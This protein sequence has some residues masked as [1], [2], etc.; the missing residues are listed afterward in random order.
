MTVTVKKK[1][2]LLSID[3]NSGEKPEKKKKNVK[4][5][6]SRKKTPKTL[7]IVESP[8]KARTIN[9]YLKSGYIVEAC[10]GH[11]I[12]LPKSRLAVDVEHDFAPE[13]ITV[14]GRAQILNRLKRLAANSRKV[15]IA[16][17]PDREGEAIAWHL[18]NVL[19]K[20]LADK[21]PPIR[22][23]EFNEISENAIREVVLDEKKHR[24]INMNLVNAQQA[25]RILDRL[26]GYNISP[27]L[28]QKIKRGLSAGRVQSVAL[29]QICMREKSILKFKPEEYWK[30]Q[31]ELKF[32][33]STITADLIKWDGKKINIKDKS[34]SN[35]IC[36]ILREA[37]YLVTGIREREKKRH[38]TPPY[39]TSKLQQD[40]S[41]R[42]SFASQKTMIVAQQLYEGVQIDEKNAS[43][44][45]TYM[46]TDSTR[47]SDRA[48]LSLHQYIAKEYGS[49][50]LKQRTYRTSKKAQDAHEA[51]RPV[52]VQKH[53]QKIKSYLTKDQF[54]LYEMIW[55]KFVSSQMADEVAK[56]LTIEIRADKGLLAARESHVLFPGFTKVFGSLKKKESQKSS[57][58]PQLKKDAPLS[59]HKLLPSQHFTQ[60]PPRFND[61]SLVKILEESGVGRPSTYA[62]TIQ[63]LQKRY[64]ITRINKAF[65]P[66]EVGNIVNQI[67]E[68]HFTDLVDIGFTAKMEDSLDQIAQGQLDEENDNKKKN[69]GTKENW[70]N[71]LHNFYPPFAE[72]IS[73]A[74]VEIE[75]LKG[76]LDK[77]TDY[78]C[79]K[80]DTNMVKRLGRNGYFLACPRFPDCRNAQSIPLG[81]CPICE[82][83]SIVKKSMR[84]R[85]GR[86]FY[87]CSLYP[88]CD[89]VT[90]HQPIEENC[91][92]CNRVL[93]S[94]S[95]KQRGHFTYCVVCEPQSQNE[96]SQKKKS[97]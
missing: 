95:S 52:E 65:Q 9:R 68:K 62:P 15:L 90:W 69:N 50:Y 84:R 81:A 88:D 67:M 78:K 13:Y 3:K 14:R 82:K 23:I 75:D 97:G 43:G 85:A 21:S 70:V 94:H 35:E 47:T 56:Q 1:V 77:P 11:I 44:L 7:V 6:T 86:H 5:K 45:I 53:P 72:L 33:K 57:K 34:K 89:F 76:K 32:K 40:A 49:E 28:W 25:R 92:I 38:P 48:L 60:P 36:T 80:C 4:K 31:A 61:A 83:G 73:K 30:I 16:A 37:N 51:I 46:R 58:M 79:E 22:R 63:T 71:M 18:R 10:M 93:F 42:L 24:D 39:T 20:S 64:Y 27:I 8:A 26:V 74:G 2:K 91:P 96:S 87:G 54:R 66:T 29:R 41:H 12:D 55:Q 59:L 19:N 17:D